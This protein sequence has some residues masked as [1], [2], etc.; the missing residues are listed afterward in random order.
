MNNVITTLEMKRKRLLEQRHKI[1]EECDRRCREIDTEIEKINSAFEVL[2][3]AIQSYICPVCNGSGN[4]RRADAAG[5]MEDVEC[6]ACHGTGV[7]TG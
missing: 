5:Q 3:E 1:K 7:K 4:I 2:N 6:S